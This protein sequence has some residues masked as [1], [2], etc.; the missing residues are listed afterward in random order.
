MCTTLTPAIGLFQKKKTDKGGGGEMGGWN[1]QGLI[2]N[3]IEFSGVI[4]K[5]KIKWNFQGSWF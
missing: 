3:K 1:F 5:E 4:N 2:K